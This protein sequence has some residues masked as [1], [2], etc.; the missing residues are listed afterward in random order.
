MPA[1]P[2]PMQ[3]LMEKMTQMP[4]Q[5][6]WMYWQNEFSDC[7]KCYACRSACPLCYCTQCTVEMNKPQFIPIASHTQGN[8][9][10]HIMRA[11]HLAGRCISCGECVRACPMEIPLGLLTAKLNSE[12]FNQFGQQAGINADADYAL[13]SF[14]T[15]DKENFFR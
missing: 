12:V 9:E 2:V 6:R 15:D 8:M 10:W 11:M 13:S 4:L 1:M 5:E 7:I 14:K 3:Q